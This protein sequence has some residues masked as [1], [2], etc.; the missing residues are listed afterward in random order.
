MPRRATPLTPLRIRHASPDAY[1]LRDGDG[2]HLIRTPAGERHWR[3][4]YY[5]PMA[6]RNR[7]ALGN[8]RVVSLASNRT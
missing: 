3:L 1:P 6:A 5:R 2:L 7:L 4:K 8:L